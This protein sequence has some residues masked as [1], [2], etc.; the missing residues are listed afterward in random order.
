MKKYALALSLGLIYSGAAVARIQV[1]ANL[2]AG[3]EAL[4]E[5]VATRSINLR[6]GNESRYFRY[7]LYESGIVAEGRVTEQSDEGA[8]VAVAFYQYDRVNTRAVRSNFDK[9]LDGTPFAESTLTIKWDEEATV[10][11]T[12]KNGTEAAFT[13]K[14]TKPQ[15]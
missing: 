12:T 5:R 13:L 7:Y 11:A 9:K 1:K 4:P 14:L 15:Q 6:D 3:E 2:K 8:T 10:T